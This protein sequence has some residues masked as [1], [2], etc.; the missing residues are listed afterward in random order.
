MKN[1]LITATPGFLPLQPMTT[2]IDNVSGKAKLAIRR[3]GAKPS[4]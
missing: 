4:F 2:I 1:E 3:E